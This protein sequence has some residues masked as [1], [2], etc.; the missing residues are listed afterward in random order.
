[1]PL[2]RHRNVPYANLVE[3]HTRERIVNHI[4]YRSSVCRTNLMMRP[5]ILSIEQAN[6]LDADASGQLAVLRQARRR[7]H[8]VDIPCFR[9]VGPLPPVV[10]DPDCSSSHHALGRGRNYFSVSQ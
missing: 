3:F 7:R 4:R 8:A 10:I 1:V 6:L 5:P 9:L 2:H